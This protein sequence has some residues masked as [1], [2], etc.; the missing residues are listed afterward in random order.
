MSA[1]RASFAQSTSN[2]AWS[3]ATNV[4]AILPKRQSP[5]LAWAPGPLLRSWERI[6]MASGVPRRTLSLC[7]D[8][9][10]EAVDAVI[11]GDAAISDFRDNPGII[12]ADILE[13][14]GRILMRKACGKHGPFEDVLS[15]HPDFFRRMESLAFGRD[16]SCVGA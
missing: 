15:D 10:R 12:E 2:A 11:N 4:N 14:A 7:P 8:W 5:H 16:F 6:Q 13:E 1:Q 3:F 9:N